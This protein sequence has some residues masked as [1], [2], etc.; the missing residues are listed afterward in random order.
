MF[1]FKPVQRI[2]ENSKSVST[3]VLT[4]LT[5]CTLLR[6]KEATFLERVHLSEIFPTHVIL[7]AFLDV[8]K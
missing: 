1:L 6:I 8:I 4:G 5:K 3:A 7:K 2:E